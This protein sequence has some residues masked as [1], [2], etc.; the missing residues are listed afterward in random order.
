MGVTQAME[1]WAGETGVGSGWARDE[2]ARSR[3]GYD[4]V[5]LVPGPLT[6]TITLSR[7]ELQGWHA[8]PASTLI[9]RSWL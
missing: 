2:G 6:T 3:G 8:V 7:L 9:F 4:P 1:S 5:N